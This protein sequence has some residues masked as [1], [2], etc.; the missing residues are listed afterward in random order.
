MKKADYLKMGYTP[1]NSTDE[2]SMDTLVKVF[3]NGNGWI[4]QFNEEVQEDEVGKVYL[5]ADQLQTL[6]NLQK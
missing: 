4:V 3:D 2:E 5:K 6:L 1:L